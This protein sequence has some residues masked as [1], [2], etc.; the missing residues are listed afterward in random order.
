[1][2]DGEVNDVRPRRRST[3]SGDARRSRSTSACSSPGT[4]S[5][6]ARR[7]LSAR[8]N[9]DERPDLLP[10]RRATAPRTSRSSSFPKVDRLA[11][12]D[13]RAHDYVRDHR[14][15]PR[16]RTTA[17]RSRALD[18]RRPCA[19]C[20][21][22]TAIGPDAELSASSR[23]PPPRSARSS[24]SPSPRPDRLRREQRRLDRRGAF[25]TRRLVPLDRRRRRAGRLRDGL[26][27][28]PPRRRPRPG[29]GRPDHGPL[30]LHDRPPLPAPRLRTRRHR[31]PRRAR[32]QPAGPRALRHDLRRRPRRPRRLLPPP[33]LPAD[34]PARRRRS[35]GGD[36]LDARGALT[37]A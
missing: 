10:D 14:Q 15:R 32:S 8:P 24:T 35:R 1:M 34:R 28:D 33:G 21:T 18:P 2:A 30:A 6:S 5:A 29:L 36:A 27:P 7:P 25:R 37:S 4:A 3:R 26:R 9:R 23:S 11:F 19:N 22:S 31:P 12:S 17:P 13:I 16:Q 20:G